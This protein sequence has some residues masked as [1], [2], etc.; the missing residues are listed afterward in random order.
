MIRLLFIFVLLAFCCVLINGSHLTLGAENDKEHSITETMMRQSIE[1]MNFITFVEKEQGSADFENE[2]GGAY[3][4]KEKITINVTSLKRYM[5]NKT[6]VFHDFNVNVV[7]YSQK[8]LNDEMDRLEMHMSELSITSIKRSDKKNT[9]IVTVSNDFIEN[10][11]KIRDISVLDNLIINEQTSKSIFMAKY[12]V[13]GEE[14]SFETYTPG[15]CTS[16]FAARNSN[17]D[18]GVVTAGHCV[19]YTGS[20][21]GTDV[22]YNG[23]HVGDVGN[24][25][26][27]QVGGSTD[28][29]FIKL[30][31][32]FIGTT[33]L[34]TR[35]FMNDDTYHSASA[36]S[37]Y[38][39]EGMT[40]TM[41]GKETG[42]Q[43]GEITETNAIMEVE[44]FTLYN[45]IVTDI[46]LIS[47]DSGG[48]LTYWMYFGSATSHRMVMGI[49]SAGNQVESYYTTVDH[50]FDDLNI[51][52][53]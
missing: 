14:L 53:Y 43:T 52:N 46:V 4:D 15:S 8:A 49:A 11:K 12:V 23:R 9:L 28:A 22:D 19:Y 31:S 38:M 41:Y 42:V 13:N 30:R 37:S 5:L 2:F 32:P 40:V 47:G 44:D 10:E 39:I 48:A 20:V 3:F 25:S 24:S 18:P 29:A 35:T 51:T 27:W 16:G 21:R 6:E 34:P 26:T 7:K 1:L 36:S 17:G 33:W 45:T 50:I